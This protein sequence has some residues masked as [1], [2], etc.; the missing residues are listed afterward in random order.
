MHWVANVLHCEIDGESKWVELTIM[1]IYLQY[2]DQYFLVFNTHDNKVNLGRS[3]NFIFTSK[4]E[5]NTM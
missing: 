5:V 4:A 1:N 2:F 3:L